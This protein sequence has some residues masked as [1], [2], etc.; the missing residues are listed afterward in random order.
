MKIEKK[1]IACSILA[2]AIGV[3][4]VLPLTFL[5]SATAKVNAIPENLSSEPWFSIDVPYSY[6][7]TR[8]G[9]IE[10]M[11]VDSD[12]DETTLV[13]S[14]Y[15]MALNITLN[16]DTTN[17]PADARI[18]YYQINV[19]SD[20]GP[21]EN[22]CWFVGTNLNGGSFSFQD[23]IEDFHFSRDEWFD[24]DAFNTANDGISS[25]VV[26]RDWATGFS[27]LWRVGSSGAG[28]IGH[29]GTSDLVSALREAETL[30]ISISRVGWITF[31]ANSTLVTLANNEVVE[32]VQ[33][34]KFGEGFLYNSV[35]PEEE[36]A[37]ID[38]TSPPISFN[39]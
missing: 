18:E 2:L 38:L 36:L 39:N 34:E 5:M 29:S 35:V 9:K 31:T 32:Q 25:G 22:G 27:L 21:V 20:K 37:T 7:M 10:G 19:T 14:Q 6:W 28:T 24:T 12:I 30:T 3:S 33:L 4:S 26:R 11:D 17:Y 13:S 1:L 8:D 16:V 15:L 23:F